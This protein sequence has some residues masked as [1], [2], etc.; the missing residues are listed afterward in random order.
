MTDPRPAPMFI[1]DAH[2][3]DFL[4]TVAAPWGS[5]IEWL[6]N[7][8]ELLAWLEQAGLV[9]ADVAR[10]MRADTIPGELDA[11]AA[12]ARVLREWFR[13]FVLTHAGHPVESKV[14]AE[15]G[16]LNRLLERDEVYGE[17][18][19]SETH[20]AQTLAEAPHDHGLHWHWR[21]RWRTPDT[22]LLPIA[23]AMADLICDEDFT[24]VKNC[25]G[26]TCTMLFLDTTKGHARRWC[27]MAVCGNRAKQA[28]HRARAKSITA[29]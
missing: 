28:T 11:V 19:A 22:L 15:L 6:G 13:N 2:G 23:Q 4:N 1:A 12:Q 14:L 27:S 21:R 17:I 16:P 18:V 26:P 3:L 5:D 20:D 24:M 29:R 25:E 7:G 8:Q 10:T 9:T